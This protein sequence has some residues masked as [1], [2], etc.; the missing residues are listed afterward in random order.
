MPPKG[1]VKALAST[2]TDTWITVELTGAK[3]AAY[4]REKIFSKVHAL[5]I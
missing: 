5:I 4:I 3:N 1:V 2:D